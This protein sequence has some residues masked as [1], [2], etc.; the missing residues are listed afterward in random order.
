M[1]QH[2]ILVAKNEHQQKMKGALRAS[3]SP[4][5][6]SEKKFLYFQL[7]IGRSNFK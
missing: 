7:L 5:P 2:E 6:C 4:V 1:Q 3:F